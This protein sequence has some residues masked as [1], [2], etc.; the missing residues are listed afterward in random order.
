MGNVNVSYA[1]GV[2][3]R[4]S[5]LIAS[6][7][8]SLSAGGLTAE[9]DAAGNYT[10]TSE[11]GFGGPVVVTFISA[12]PGG[13]DGASV[14][15]SG[16]I[17]VG[18]NYADNDAAKTVDGSAAVAQDAYSAVDVGGAEVTVSIDCTPSADGV[19]VALAALDAPGGAIYGD[20]AYVNPSG[21]SKAGVPMTLALTYKPASGTLVPLVQV[22][23]GTATF[24][25][26]A[27]YRAPSIPDLAVGANE[28][29]LTTLA[30]A[31]IDGSFDAVTNVADL[32]PGVP[33][34]A[35]GASSDVSL[36]GG[37][38]ALG[39]DGAGFDNITVAAAASSPANIGARVWA[40]G[41]GRVD[42]VI[43]ALKN[44]APA[45]SIGQF[46]A[47]TA[48]AAPVSISGQVLDADTVWV[49]V[50]GVGGGNGG[51][52]VDDLKVTQVQDLPEYFDA[53]LYGL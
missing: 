31:P 50:Q 23:G 28:L 11:A 39:E 21:D 42:I 14:L 49:T 25:N 44:F 40:A 37:A 16:S 35:E 3:V 43:T 9:I 48:N 47:A 8:P 15:A 24:T 33:N 51:I 30:G 22:V 32:S 53:D 52:L 13:M 18:D 41:S 17:S 36:V 38:V 46:R 4:S 5:S 26:L 34:A 19:S 29:D 45:T 10:L 20:L 7:G 6:G 27:V 12:G 2:R 1:S